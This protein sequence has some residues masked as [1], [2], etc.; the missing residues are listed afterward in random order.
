[1]E[2]DEPWWISNKKGGG[3]GGGVSVR[4]STMQKKSGRLKKEHRWTGWYNEIQKHIS[5]GEIKVII[6]YQRGKIKYRNVSL[7]AVF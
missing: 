3:G 4:H 2:D 7:G 6:G 1:M 5:C